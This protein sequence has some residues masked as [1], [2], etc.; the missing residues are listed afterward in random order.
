MP[1]RLIRPVVE[2]TTRDRILKA[3]ILRF[4]SHSYEETGLRD[5][6]S[7]V[8]VDMAYVHRSFGSKEKL[9]REAVRAMLRPEVWLV[10]EASELH[11]TLAKDVLA[12]KGAN[13]IRP[14]DILARSFSSPEAARVFRELIDE[15]FVKPFASK[16]QLVSEPRASMIA[17]LLAGVSI[18]R[19]VI[20]TPALQKSGKDHELAILISQVVEF[21][22]NDDKECQTTATLPISRE[23]Q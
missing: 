15:G 5:I 14:F 12:D 9:F 7:D 8:G 6:A 1:N 21:L 20:G 2:N 17:A 11:M 23:R 10:G 19:D 13:E 4:S 22:M 3:A 18:L 16:C